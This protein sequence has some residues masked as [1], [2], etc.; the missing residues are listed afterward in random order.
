MC[1]GGTTNLT[2]PGIAQTGRRFGYCFQAVAGP[3][4]GPATG[5]AP[6]LPEDGYGDTVR[7]SLLPGW[8]EC[9]LERC[10]IFLLRSL[11]TRRNQHQE[12]PTLH[13]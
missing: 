2:F 8:L 7:F 10:Q 11:R 9:P 1:R 3:S 4:A 6:A 13:S 5:K 12:I